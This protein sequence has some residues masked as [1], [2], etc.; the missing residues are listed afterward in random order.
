M[1]RTSSTYQNKKRVHINM[2]WKYIIC[3]LQLK[4]YIYKYVLK[5]S[6]VNYNASLETSH[7]GALCPFR[8]AALVAESL[9]GIH[10][11]T[12]VMSHR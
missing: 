7:Q 4:Q 5:M 6:S 2:C 1:L 12:L 3:E 8:D 10:S 11:A 9:T